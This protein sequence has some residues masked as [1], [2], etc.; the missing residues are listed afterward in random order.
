MK[1][2]YAVQHAG[3][4][5]GG[6]EGPIDWL[7][8]STHT[9]LRGAVQAERKALSDMRQACGPNAW[10]NHFRI[11]SLRDQKSATNVRCGICGEKYTLTAD[12]AEGD[13]I[14][15]PLTCKYCWGPLA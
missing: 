4:P 12:Y 15:D 5:Y 1:H 13:Q 2:S 6:S 3:R 14:L 9:T 7:E 11:V 8:Y 10:N